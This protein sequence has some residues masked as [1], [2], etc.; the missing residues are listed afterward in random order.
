MTCTTAGGRICVDLQSDPR[1]C[2]SCGNVCAS[3]ICSRGVC[4]LP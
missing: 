3:G 1:N 2:G 4:A